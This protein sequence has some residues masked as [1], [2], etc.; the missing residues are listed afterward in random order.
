MGKI[1]KIKTDS[2]VFR[3]AVLTILWLVVSGVALLTNG[4]ASS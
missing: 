2:I 4:H 3:I 1:K